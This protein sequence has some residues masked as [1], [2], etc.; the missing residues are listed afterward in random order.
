MSTKFE[1]MINSHLDHLEVKFDKRFSGNDV[2]ASTS[3]TENA[4]DSALDDI[5]NLQ[6]PKIP[7]GAS[8]I[9]H[10]HSRTTIGASASGEGTMAATNAML[11]HTV[12][13][14]EPPVSAHVPLSNAHSSLRHVSNTLPNQTSTYSTPQPTVTRTP[15]PGS[16]RPRVALGMKG[17]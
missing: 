2:N 3:N 17:F 9:H 13:F 1:S 5:S 11:P 6:I 7:I 8:P 15:H 14:S 16:I 4:T 10:I 12:A